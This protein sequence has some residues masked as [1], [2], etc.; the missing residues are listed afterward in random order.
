LHPGNQ[1]TLQNTPLLA[2]AAA[3]TIEY[4]LAH[5]GGH[6]GWSRAWIINFFA[7]LR[8]SEKAYQNLV[9]LLT[10]ST[11]INL[12]DN[13]P[14]FQIDGNFGGTAG[15]AEMLLQSHAG[16]TDLLPALPAEWHTGHVKGLVAR[17]GFEISMAWEKGKLTSASVRSNHGNPLNLSY[18]GNKMSLEKTTPGKIYKFSVDNAGNLE[19][20]DQ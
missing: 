20:E 13:H 10:K 5:G 2:E 16:E 1:I 15:I 19:P 18:K 9:A 8:N 3:K 12:F 6:T 14:P 17:G 11:L 7:R 4:R